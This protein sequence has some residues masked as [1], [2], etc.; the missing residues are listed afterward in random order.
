MKKIQYSEYGGPEVMQMESVERP[1]PEAD[2]VLV[3][4]YAAGI[5]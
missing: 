3:K 1:D 2:E 4:V 5:N